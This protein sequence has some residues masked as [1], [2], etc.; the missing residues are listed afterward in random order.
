M[1]GFRLRAPGF[2]WQATFVL[3]LALVLETSAR[4]GD[5]LAPRLD[6]V[7]GALAAA[8]VGV[9]VVDLGSGAVVYERAGDRP[10]TLASNTKLVTT[11]VALDRLGPGY[12]FETTLARRGPIAADLLDGD[13]VVRGGADPCLGAR[14][15][16]EAD[17]ALRRLARAVREAGVRRVRGDLVADDRFLDRE[18][19]HAEWPKNQ[20]DRWY[21]APVSALALNDGCVDVTVAPGA[22]VG[23]PAIVTLAPAS[24]AF[25][26]EAR[27]PTT[28]DKKEHVVDI[29]RRA[30]GNKIVVRGAILLGSEP[31][32]TSIGVA[33]PA[34]VFATVLRERL[35]AEGVVVEG[36]TRL[37]APGEDLAAGAAPLAVHSSLLAQALPVVNKRSQNHAAELLLKTLG[38]VKGGGGSWKAGLEVEAAF[39]EATGVAARGSYELT[40]GSGL[41]RGNRLAA[42]AVAR[43]LGHMA[44]HEHASTWLASLAG[45]G[46]DGTLKD[47][48]RG[49][50]ARAR[51][52]AKTGTINAVSALSGYVLP[53]EGAPGAA[54][55][56]GF[57]FSIMVNGLKGGPA[58]ARKAQDEAVE[59]LVDALLGV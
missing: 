28:S 43:L 41:A 4:A 8:E 32:V 9:A 19:Q 55:G 24:A 13:L 23:A 47:R 27:C 1:R 14:F 45:A 51:I 6:R 10:L 3:V 56:Q 49:P 17:G 11:A 22:K 59:A 2:G 57:A 18:H 35:A 31:I 7:F 42:R 20:L 26:V 25:E 15:D 5:G 38:A 37:A 30:G 53:R 21:A 33:D 29:G 12:R 36:K 34:I 44:R 50:S 46:S 39:L 54:R 52:L 16:G 58:A 40:D 48:L